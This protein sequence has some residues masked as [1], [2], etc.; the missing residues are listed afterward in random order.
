MRAAISN[1]THAHKPDDTVSFL[2]L[3]TIPDELFGTV[4]NWLR[5]KHRQ[6][7]MHLCNVEPSTPQKWVMDQFEVIFII[8]LQEF[9]SY[10]DKI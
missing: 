6:Y 10:S 5:S 7:T 3:E 2:L 4:K 9:D 1:G 8:I